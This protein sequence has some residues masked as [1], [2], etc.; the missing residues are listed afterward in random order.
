[1]PSFILNEKIY[2]FLKWLVLIFLPALSALYFSLGSVYG[3]A[4]TEQVVGTIAIIATFLGATVGISSKNF[5]QSDAP[6]DGDVKV[7]YD[8]NLDKTVYAL[9]LNENVG[10]EDIASKDR[11]TFKVVAK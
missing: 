10:V 1:M 3:W 6:F 4:N 5:N 9:E 7:T 2:A 8:A 11:L